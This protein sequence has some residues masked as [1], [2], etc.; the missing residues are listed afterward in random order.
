MIAKSHQKQ[1]FFHRTNEA[2][3]SF[4]TAF[5]EALAN[6]ITVLQGQI[7]A[8]EHIGTDTITAVATSITHGQ[9]LVEGA[10]GDIVVAIEGYYGQFYGA[11]IYIGEGFVQG[12]GA[13]DGQAYD[14][15]WGLSDSGLRGIED[16]ARIAS[17]AKE[18]IEDGAFIGEGLSLGIISKLYEVWRAGKEVASAALDGIETVKTPTIT[19]VVDAGDAKVEASTLANWFADN[20]KVRTDSI[21][22]IVNKYRDSK[23]SIDENLSVKNNQQIATL[24]NEVA[25]LSKKLERMTVVLDSGELVGAIGDKV[26]TTLGTKVLSKKRGG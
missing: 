8:F 12:I 9:S 10:V 25:G 22:N 1:K 19:P 16:R 17:P 15:G 18:A 20:V 21:G 23:V 2:N 3:L 4:Q 13:M 24:G 11:G 5:E 7:P 6:S 26:D 14:A